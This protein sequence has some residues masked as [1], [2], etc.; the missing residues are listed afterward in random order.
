ML[1]VDTI[2]LIYSYLDFCLVEDILD[3]ILP[4]NLLDDAPHGYTAIGHIGE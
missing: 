4:D 3:A 2:P 1:Y